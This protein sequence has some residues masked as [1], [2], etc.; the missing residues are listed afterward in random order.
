VLGGTAA[1]PGG[2]KG[3]K[4]GLI[5]GVVAFMGADGGNGLAARSSH[6]L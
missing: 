3:R 4:I 1:C 6:G 5:D 2:E